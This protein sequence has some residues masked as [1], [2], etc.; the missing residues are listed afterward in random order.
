MLAAS[1]PAA[2]SGATW[3][4]AAAG[5]CAPGAASR[6]QAESTA[7]PTSAPTTAARRVPRPGVMLPP[8][9]RSPVGARAA[10]A[11]SAPE[12][13]SHE[14]PP[15]PG[16]SELGRRPLSAGERAREVRRPGAA[17]DRGRHGGAGG[18]EH[19][20]EHD[21]ARERRSEHHC[22]RDRHH[23]RPHHLDAEERGQREERAVGDDARHEQRQEQWNV[24][25]PGPDERREEHQRGGHHQ[26]RAG[27]SEQDRVPGRLGGEVGRRLAS[28]P[29]DPGQDAGVHRPG[30]DLEQ[31]CARHRHGVDA[32]R[33]GRRQRG[34]E[35]EGELHVQQE[36]GVRRD[37]AQPETDAAQ[38]RPDARRRAR[39]AA[40]EREQVHGE[41]RQERHERRR[42][43]H[44]GGLDP[45]AEGDRHGQEDEWC[46]HPADDDRVEGDHM[47]HRLVQALHVG[48]P[49]Q[50]RRDRGR[51]SHD[52]PPVAEQRRDG[53]G[54]RADDHTADTGDHDGVGHERVEG[55]PSL[56]DVD[57]KRRPDR[58]E[59]HD[60]ERRGER[61][62]RIEAPP[63]GPEE[64]RR[65]EDEQCLRGD[66]RSTEGERLRS[67]C[68]ERVR[69]RALSRSS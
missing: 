66:L 69:H 34:E 47:A 25:I 42:P 65:H 14:R 60:A 21:H 63:F 15:G 68:G 20:D 8:Q 29:P 46:E 41:D 58:S 19:G 33:C 38:E 30:A 52:P 7:T 16:T 51:Q 53:D 27:R 28:A 6:R 4:V 17:A 57:A 39:G 31:L 50:R 49:Q 61:R 1:S 12:R 37:E 36:H 9:P 64:P 59:R 44:H 62:E 24:A 45:G 35:E 13:R 22:R 26:R 2:K 56:R 32:D 55:P 54:E 11:A 5:R 18:A 40:R 48:E 3:R 10:R 67:T 43:G 23:L